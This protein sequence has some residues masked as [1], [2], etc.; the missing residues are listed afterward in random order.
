MTPIELEHRILRRID[1]GKGARHTLAID[2]ERDA[3]ELPA[4]KPSG[5]PSTRSEKQRVGPV[6]VLDHA[7]R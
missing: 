2:V 5:A 7:R 4:W 6:P 3:H 1:E